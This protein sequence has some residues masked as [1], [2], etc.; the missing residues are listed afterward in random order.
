[1]EGIIRLF[2]TIAPDFQVLWLAAKDLL[3]SS[4][5]YQNPQI[6]TGVGYPPNTLLFYLP[7]T[8]MNYQL[9][10][11]LFT[12]L[13]LLS[14]LGIIYLSLNLLKIKP[15]YILEISIFIVVIIAFPTKFTLGMGQNNLITFFLLL[16][17]FYLYLKKNYKWTGIVLGLSFSFKT[18]FIYFLIYYILKKE[19]KVI[20]YS[21]LTLI[22]TT[23]IIYLIRGNLYLYSYYT[24]VVLPP[25]SRFEGR[26]IYYNQ[27]LSGFISRMVT[28]IDLRKN[29][30]ALT[31][32]ILIS[33]NA[34]IIFTKNKFD[35]VISFTI[36]TL[37]LLDSLAWQHHFVFLIF[38][39]IVL[40]KYSKSVMSIIVIL[41]SYV[42]AAINVPDI[43]FLSS[44][45]FFATLLLY[46]M[47][48]KYLK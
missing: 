37:L 22:L 48:L 2:T 40:I 19:W 4:N 5:P 44:N 43:T 10:Q 36:I 42:L 16:L 7:L 28:D 20:V 24:Q 11:N 30:T 25:L 18:I 1:M 6:F 13:S 27:G 33:V 31:S 38:P 34:Y 3:T 9:A 17:S 41:S 45:L 47:N 21:I 12:L 29:L 15:T 26:E 8:I 32:L 23:I 39:F 14:I 35:L 46:I